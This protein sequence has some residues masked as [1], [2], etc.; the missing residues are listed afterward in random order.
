MSNLHEP[1]AY[2]FEAS[3]HCQNCAKNR[4]GL[5]DN[6][7]ITGTDNEGETVAA[8]YSWEAFEDRD[9]AC[10]TCGAVIRL[11]PLPRNTRITK[12]NFYEVEDLYISYE[13][14]TTMV[15]E[16]IDSLSE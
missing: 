2:T 7:L 9:M 15:D 16:Y 14:V 12:G 5:D 8:V 1:I 4:F 13:F 3:E 6:G 11:L 10:G